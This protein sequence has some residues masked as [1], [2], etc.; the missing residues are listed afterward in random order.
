MK[1]AFEERLLAELKYIVEDRRENHAT[2]PAPQLVHRRLRRRITVVTGIAAALALALLLPTIGRE[3]G[4]SAA[5]AVTDNGDGTVRV[6]IRSIHDPE[7][8]ERKLEE[9]GVPAAV[10][11]LPQNKNCAPP[12]WEARMRGDST[13]AGRA[14]AAMESSPAARGAV[15]VS[16]SEDGAFVFTIDKSKLARDETVVV[17]AEDDEPEHGQNAETVASIAP[18]VFKGDYYEKCELVDG[19]MEGWGFQQGARAPYNK[20]NPD[21][22]GR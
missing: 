15:G 2:Q 6:E 1:Q 8:L 10:H 16:E 4:S 7:G 21:L 12:G 9:A 3:R 19:S 14:E 5:Y 20:P 22:Q 13:A 18:L 11:Y 17:F